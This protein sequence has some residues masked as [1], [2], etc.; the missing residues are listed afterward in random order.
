VISTSSSEEEGS[1]YD[2]GA[3]SRCLHRLI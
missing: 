3:F 1:N 2:S